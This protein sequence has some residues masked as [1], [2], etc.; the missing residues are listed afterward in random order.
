V[1]NLGDDDVAIALDAV[2][3]SAGIGRVVETGARAV[4]L[5]DKRV[6]VGPIDPC[7]ECEVCRRGG[8][9]VCPSARRRTA[10]PARVTA[11]A[12]WAIVLG[13]GLDANAP[14]GAAIAG[15]VAIAYTLYARTGAAPREPVVV[16]G[17]TPVTR[18]LVEILAAKGLTF[19]VH[20]DAAPNAW[21]A[22]LATKGA[23]AAPGA[24]ELEAHFAGMGLARRPW[25]V[26]A[27]SADSVPVAA[28]LAGPRATLTVLAP[29]ASLP[30]ELATREVTVITVAGAHPDLV[31]EAAAMCVKGEI[32]LANGTAREASADHRA[33]V[34]LR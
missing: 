6:L 27:T 24:A 9:A 7:G 13:D 1:S 25:R 31:V 12:R 32:D 3:G 16:V 22:W 30:G 21:T 5:A 20:V 29:I 14:E 23:V 11:A 17:A 18:F 26:I 34:E 15:D 33:I 28:G 19:A 8:A 4:G 2:Q 10:W